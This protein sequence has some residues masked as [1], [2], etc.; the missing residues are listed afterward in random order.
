MQQAV[1]VRRRFRGPARAPLRGLLRRESERPRALSR[2]RESDWSLREAFDRD[3]D[4]FQRV[5]GNRPDADDLVAFPDALPVAVR[6]GLHGF[7]DAVGVKVQTEPVSDHHHAKVRVALHP[8]VGSTRRERDRPARVAPNGV[9]DGV[10]RRACRGEP[11]ARH[12]VADVD[13]FLVRLGAGLDGRDGAVVRDLDAEALG[14][15]HDGYELETDAVPSV[16]PPHRQSNRSPRM[17]R[18]GGGDGAIR[19]RHRIGTDAGKNVAHV[20]AFCHGL[21]AR[22][23][24]DD[25]AVFG[26][27]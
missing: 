24:R 19:R 12:A 6:A 18:D 20:D 8:V 23:A 11:D 13:V 4:V 27:R 1:E 10:F 15:Y 14:V 3:H 16:V 7:H 25:A 9:E 17:R 26:E 5:D 22:L 2:H 21:A